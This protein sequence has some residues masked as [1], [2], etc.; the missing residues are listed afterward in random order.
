[1]FIPMERLDEQMKKYKMI[2]ACKRVKFFAPHDEDAFFEWIKKLTCVVDAV[3]NKD[4]M[5]LY[6]T[7]KK[8]SDEQ[9]R[10]LI[11]LCRRYKIPLKKLD[12]LINE[13]NRDY[14]EWCKT[15]FS[16][17]VYPASN[18]LPHE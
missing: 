11:G 3:G 15:G 8:I 9:L 17:N 1:M 7:N 13:K 16:I 18:A 10:S 12:Q 14:F 4:V 5:Y 6:I 2:L